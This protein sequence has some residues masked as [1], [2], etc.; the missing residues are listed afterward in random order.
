MEPR[1]RL[2]NMRDAPI[3]L[4]MGQFALSMGQ[5]GSHAV[6]KDVQTKLFEKE[7]VK[8]M[9]G[10]KHCNLRL[11]DWYG[12]VVKRKKKEQEARYHTSFLNEA[13]RYMNIRI[14]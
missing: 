11:N 4:G 6:M 12:A 1:R 3:K 14:S 13:K 5:K 7:C 9:G 2:A 8:G 10:R